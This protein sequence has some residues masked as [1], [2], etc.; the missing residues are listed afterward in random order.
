MPVFYV[1]RCLIQSFPPLLSTASRR[2]FQ[3]S[4]HSRLFFCFC[5]IALLVLPTMAR[6]TVDKTDLISLPTS[7]VNGTQGARSLGANDCNGRGCYYYANKTVRGNG[8]KSF[9][10]SDQVTCCNKCF[11]NSD[12][13]SWSWGFTG[14]NGRK[15]TCY[16]FTSSQH[17]SSGLLYTQYYNSGFGFCNGQ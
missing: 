7:P 14:N 4:M 9:K 8:F 16:F 11:A 12:C 10:T 17:Q 2:G 1:C 6:P 13:Y 3:V 5:A 15:N